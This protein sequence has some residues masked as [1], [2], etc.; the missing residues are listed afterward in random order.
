MTLRPCKNEAVVLV[1]YVHYESPRNA[2]L[3]VNSTNIQCGNA[4]FCVFVL[5]EVY[6][7]LQSPERQW[8]LLVSERYDRDLLDYDSIVTALSFTCDVVLVETNSRVYYSK[9]T[10]VF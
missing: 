5:K 10:P 6:F 7:I 8:C 4:L 2:F 3:N 9:F 1:I